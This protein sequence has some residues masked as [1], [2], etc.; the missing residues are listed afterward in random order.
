MINQVPRVSIGLPVYNGEQ[1]VAEAIRCVLAQT[2]EDWEL[3]VCDN[4]ST[5]QTVTICLDFAAHDGRIRIHQNGRNMGAAFNFNETFRLA[6]G[7]YFKWITHD[8]LFAPEFIA[9]CVKALDDDKG[10]VMSFPAISYVDASGCLLRRQKTC[11]SVLE[12]TPALRV[13]RLTRLERESTDI[14]W[15]IYGL[16]RRDV[17]LQTGLHGLYGGSDQVLLLELV[18]HGGIK[19]VDEDLFFRREHPGASSVRHQ[20]TAKDRAKF[21]YADDTRKVVFPYCRILKEHVL[22]ILRSTLPPIA[23]LQCT[24]AVLR[25]FAAQWKYFAEELIWSPLDA[26]RCNIADYR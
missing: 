18:L 6:R 11:L 5:D 23:R 14:Y 7:R 24:R 19:Q 15:A 17:L 21:A 13:E 9:T 8:D 16:M 3:I 12:E 10:I 22:C 2:F 4:A 25:R 26:L 20:W 1:F